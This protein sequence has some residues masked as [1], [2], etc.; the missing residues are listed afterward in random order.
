MGFRLCRS[1]AL[2][3]C[4]NSWSVQL[5]PDSLNH[6]HHHHHRWRFLPVHAGIWYLL[7]LSIDLPIIHACLRPASPWLL[8]LY[9]ET[10]VAGATSCKLCP[11]THK[12]NRLLH[13][14]ETRVTVCVLKFLFLIFC[15]V[16]LCCYWISTSLPVGI[17]FEKIISKCHATMFLYLHRLFEEY[18]GG[19]ICLLRVCLIISK[20][21]FYLF[22]SSASNIANHNNCFN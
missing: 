13:E 12:F 21:R 6:H 19:L 4:Y 5:R 2:N 17:L 14:R 7:R 10:P 22:C 3:N 8:W 1:Q 11:L 18:V 20:E 16:C 15:V 9:N